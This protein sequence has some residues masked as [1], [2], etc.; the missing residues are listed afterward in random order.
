MFDFSCVLCYDLHTIVGQRGRIMKI[1]FALLA[2]VDSGKTTLTEAILYH[3]GK[4]RTMGRVDHQNTCFDTHEIERQRGITIFSEQSSFSWNGQEF[5][6]IDTPGHTDFSAEMERILP[7]LDYAVLLIDGSSGIQGHTETI[8]ELLKEYQ[9]PVL[10]F[11][12]KMDR[13]FRNKDEILEEIQKKFGEECIDFTENSQGDYSEAFLENVALLDEM[14]MQEFIEGNQDSTWWETQFTN[15][16]ATRKMFPCI[17]GSAL[18]NNNVD[19]LLS[20]LKNHAKSEKYEEKFHA[21]VYKISYDTQGNRLT[22]LK[23]LGG[24]L[25]VKMPIHHG[26]TYEK[27]NQIRIYSGTKFETVSSVEAGEVCAVTGLTFTKPGMEIWESGE[28]LENKAHLN[29]MLSAS[30]LWDKNTNIHTVAAAFKQLEE[31]MPELSVSFLE[32]TQ[33]IQIHVMGKIQ[34]EILKELVK[35]SFQLDIDFGPCCILYKETILEPV[36]GYGHYEPLRHYAEAQI[37]ISPAKRGSGIQIHNNCSIEVLDKN[38][39][40]LILT[41]IKEKEH[42]GILTGSPLTDVV[43]TLTAGRAHLKHTEGGDFREAV[44]RAIRQGLEKAKN[45]LLEPYY[46]FQIR[47]PSEMTGR[48]MSDIQRMYGSFWPPQI[49]EDET[50]LIGEGPVACFMDY[51]QEIQAYTKG[52]GSIVFRDGGYRRCHNEEEVIQTIGYEKEHDLENPSSS[53]FCSHGAGY[54][55]KWDQVD[56][57]RHVKIE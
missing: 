57:L 38:Y 55:V 54:E 36:M 31:E 29:P 33:E 37:R 35:N 11:V 44:Y 3:V 43:Y 10:L 17:F 41:H 6:L 46:T 19:K 18:Q 49:T 26:E 48:V 15:A 24:N 1:C 9:I 27:V 12:N 34:L 4:I 2:H 14:W 5:A 8:W 42:L 25:F 22:F 20:M 47:V 52:R 50:I 21:R 56:D 16:I 53:I 7:I 39:Q 23:V 28:C 32:K 40:N 30:V 45:I 13:S 51:A